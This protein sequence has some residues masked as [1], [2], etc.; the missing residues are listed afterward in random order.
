MLPEKGSASD[1][2]S[3]RGRKKKVG[4][5]LRRRPARSNG[6]HPG[7][8]PTVLTPA[9]ADKFISVMLNELISARAAM[10]KVGLVPSQVHRW[11]KMYPEFESH[12][13]EALALRTEMQE[14]E[15]IETA[16]YSPPEIAAK[17]RVQMR[18]RIWS[19]ARM[20]PRRGDWL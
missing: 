9:L 10:K 13:R 2:A 8:R 11:K 20:T 18:A 4:H 15:I 12:Y 3:R 1:G 19:L 16:D 7:G 6:K 17:A 5:T 14:D